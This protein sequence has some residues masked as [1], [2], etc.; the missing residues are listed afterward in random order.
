MLNVKKTLT[1][2]IDHETSTLTIVNGTVGNSNRCRK[3]DGMVEFFIDLEGIT[4]SSGWNTVAQ[5]PSG[6]EP[7]NYYD[8]LALNTATDQATSAKV[9]SSGAVQIFKS[10]YAGAKMRIHSMHFAKL[11]GGTP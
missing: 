8:F 6:W 5:L 1:K 11:G 4:Y 3:H 2:L 9:S 10:S 7:E